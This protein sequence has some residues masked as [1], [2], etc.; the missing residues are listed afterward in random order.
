MDSTNSI[1]D[2]VIEMKKK[3]IDFAWDNGPKILSALAILVVGLII[4]GC[5][6]NPG[7]WV[8]VVR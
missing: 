2:T 1:N 5:P 7:G 8:V 4:A 6:T 3:A